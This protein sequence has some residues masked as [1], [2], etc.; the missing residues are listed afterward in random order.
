MNQVWGHSCVHREMKLR[1][2]KQA[3]ASFAKSQSEVLLPQQ[4]MAEPKSSKLLPSG[5]TILERLN[6]I[7]QNFVYHMDNE[8][9]KRYVMKKTLDKLTEAEESHLVASED[10][11]V[12]EME[13]KSKR[14]R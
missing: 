10:N 13:P 8:C 3:N 7:E 14:T 1:L 12:D 9:Y 5:K 2:S 4:Q 6:G 11:G